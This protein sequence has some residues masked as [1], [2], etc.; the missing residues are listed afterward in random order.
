MKKW[1]NEGRTANQSLMLPSQI[2]AVADHAVGL[3]NQSVG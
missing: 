1:I 2:Y 3:K